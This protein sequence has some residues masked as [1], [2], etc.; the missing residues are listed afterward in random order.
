MKHLT[1]FMVSNVTVTLDES[2]E[3]IQDLCDRLDRAYNQSTLLHLVSSTGQYHVINP[4]NIILL[5]LEDVENPMQLRRV[6]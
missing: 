6:A 1:I 4:N 5:E 2:E 3:F